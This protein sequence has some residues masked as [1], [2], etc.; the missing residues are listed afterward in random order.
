MA[1]NL[2]LFQKYCSTWT[3]KPTMSSAAAAAASSNGSGGAGDE[4][5][6]PLY[7]EVF[8]PLAGGGGGAPQPAIPIA[9]KW[10]NANKM[11][12]RSSTVTQ[13]GTR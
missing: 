7:N 11:C 9:S 6:Q 10:N 8:P 2:P 12:L 3:Y 5:G 1:R 4:G 13:V